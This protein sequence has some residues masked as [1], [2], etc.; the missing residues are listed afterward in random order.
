MTPDRA[1]RWEQG[2]RR[3]RYLRMVG[4]EPASFESEDIGREGLSL[5]VREAI[6]EAVRLV[7]TL[8]QEI[9]HA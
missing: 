3:P 5:P 8:L 9:N 7:E 1:M 4:C 2:S 6:G